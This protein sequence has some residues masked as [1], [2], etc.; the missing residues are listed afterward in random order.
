MSSTR[1][2]KDLTRPSTSTRCSMLE[3]ERLCVQRRLGARHFEPYRNAVPEKAGPSWL[4][5]RWRHYRWIRRFQCTPSEKYA[6][7]HAAANNAR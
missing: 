5:D 7:G 6:L 4:G 2:P 1:P 3:H